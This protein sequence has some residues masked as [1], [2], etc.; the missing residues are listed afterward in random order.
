LNTTADGSLYL[1]SLDMAKWD[2][3]LYTEKLLKRSSLETMWTPVKLN[4]G[5]THG[6]GF[7]WGISSQNGHKVIEHGGAWQGFLSHISRYIDDKTTII[8]FVNT[9][10]ANPGKIAHAV[11]ELTIP[12]LAPPRA[13]P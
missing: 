4:D 9:G 8:V 12:A 2:A 10:N 11:A 7:G 1:T 5:T 3:A 6:Y 13:I